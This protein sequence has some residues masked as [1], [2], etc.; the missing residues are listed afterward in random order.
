MIIHICGASGSGKTTLGVKLSKITNTIVIDTDNIDDP[1]GLKIIKK[2][3]FNNKI[4]KQMF[5][6]ELKKKIK[7][8]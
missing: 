6:T 2:Y 5:R 7:T 1:N 8:I 3:S 4:D